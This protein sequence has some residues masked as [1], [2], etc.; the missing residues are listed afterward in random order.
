MQYTYKGTE[1]VFY[2]V[3]LVHG[4]VSEDAAG[5][6]RHEQRSQTVHAPQHRSSGEFDRSERRAQQRKM[7]LF[8]A[9]LST[10]LCPRRACKVQEAIAN[11]VRLLS[12]N[13]EALKPSRKDAATSPAKSQPS[14]TKPGAET[15]EAR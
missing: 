13:T 5:R 1:S 3:V 4:S 11:A 15:P 10:P 2:Y 8:K 7:L 12:P 14:P 9:R 6:N